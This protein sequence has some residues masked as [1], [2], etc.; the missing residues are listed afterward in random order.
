VIQLNPEVL[1]ILVVVAKAAIAIMGF[2]IKHLHA[3][4][5]AAHQ[6]EQENKAAL[7]EY[8]VEVA[9]NYATKDFIIDNFKTINHKLDKLF[10]EVHTKK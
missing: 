9:Q 4:V 1:T 3:E 5:K 7:M 10:Q 6:S 8:K 2:V